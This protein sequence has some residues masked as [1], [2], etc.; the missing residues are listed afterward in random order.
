MY[1]V[2]FEAS[3]SDGVFK[4]PE[5]FRKLH[6]VTK[7]KIIIM[8]KDEQVIPHAVVQQVGFIERLANKP[9][10]VEKTIKFL[11]REEANER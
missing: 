3:I 4:I 8:I 9:I 11:S 7:A 2:E 5:T 1:A 6:S 10:H